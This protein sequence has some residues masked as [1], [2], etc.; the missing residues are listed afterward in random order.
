MSAAARAL[1]VLLLLATA[2][3][4]SAHTVFG[5]SGFPGGLLHPVA[6]PLHL[7]AL[8]ALGLL[9]GGQGWG[10]SVFAAYAVAVLA[11]LGAI[12]LAYVPAYAELVLLALAACAGLLVALALPL[13]LT[14][15]L[16][17]AAATGLAL[18]LDSPPE[19]ISLADA[20]LALLGTALSATMASALLVWLVRHLH[21]GD[22]QRIGIRIVG[23]WIAASA[24][25]VLGLRLSA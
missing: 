8:V 3:E 19:G 21:R 10:V 9:I 2:D 5:F 16:P 11:G 23:S 14:V 25:L 4:A 6:V 24:I 15:G 1:P 12:A 20:N 18:A 22:W 7:M 13:P 17:L